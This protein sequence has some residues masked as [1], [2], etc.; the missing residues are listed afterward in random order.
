MPA[1]LPTHGLRLTALAAALLC[2]QAWPA[3]LDFTGAAPVF[4]A[5]G[6]FGQGHEAFEFA[7]RLDWEGFCNAHAQAQCD[8]RTF[9]G[10][11][12]NWAGGLRPGAADDVR[13]GTG[14]T[15]V[16]GSFN[17]LF[18]GLLPGYAQVNYLS[19]AG[20]LHI[21]PGSN[22]SA[23]QADIAHLDL[24]GV[25]SLQGGRL[26]GVNLSAG[27]LV[28]TG[29]LVVQTLTRTAGYI[30]GTGDTQILAIDA[31]SPSFSTLVTGGQRLGLSGDYGGPTDL[32]L[33]D[34]STFSTSGVLG[35][36]SI[37]SVITG[38]GAF[39]ATTQSTVVN[40]GTLLGG[41]QISG[42]RFNNDGVVRIDAGDFLALSNG[43]HSGS[44]SAGAGTTL[45]F[46]NLGSAGHVFL[47]NSTVQSD[48][49]V[50][51]Q[52]GPALVQGGYRVAVTEVGAGANVSFTGQPQ[53]F[54]RIQM[55]GGNLHMNT[56]AGVQIGVL[57]ITGASSVVTFG[58]G[59][60]SEVGDLRLDA[61]SA[62]LGAASGLQVTGT[63]TWGT[64][65]IFGGV[66]TPGQVLLVAGNR[67]LAGE[68]HNRGQA[69]WQG[70]SFSS[71]TGIWDNSASAALD[72]LGDF[73]VA[74]STGRF[75]N[76]GS[77]TK[78]AGAG[79]TTL[80][81]SFNNG[82]HVK[83]SSGALRLDGGGTQS[84]SFEATPGSWIELA[85]AQ[86][87]T[88]SVAPVGAVHITDGSLQVLA[89]ASYTNSP[90]SRIAVQAMQIDARGS[91]TNHGTVTGGAQI[92]NDGSLVNNG[93]WYAGKL[94]NQGSFSNSSGHTATLDSGISTGS[95]LNSGSLVVNTG[96]NVLG[97]FSNDGSIAN[98]GWLIVDTAL[99]NAGQ[100]SSDG[101]VVVNATASL[102][103]QGSFEQTAGLTT[104]NGL[105]EAQGGIN[106]RAGQLYG[107]G[108]LRG[109]VWV[110]SGA[111][112]HPGN[113]PGTL[114]VDGDATLAGAG[115]SI[116]VLD[117]RHSDLL[118]VSGVLTLDQTRI[119]LKFDPAYQPHD[120]DS[121]TWLRAARID[122]LGTTATFSGLPVD[123]QG[124]VTGSAT[125]RQ[126]F[127]LNDP[128]TTPSMQIA[129]SGRVQIPQGAVAANLEPVTVE[130]EELDNAGR[131]VNA[132]D[133]ALR[134]DRLINRQDATFSNRGF[135]EV[136]NQ[137]SNAGTLRV[138]PDGTLRVW[139]PL[140]NSGLLVSHGSLEL[141][142]GLNNTGSVNVG[143]G[144][145]MAL[146]GGDLVTDGGELIVS[147]GGRLQ[148]S[149]AILQRGAGN[150]LVV[151]GQLQ[152][153]LVRLFNGGELSGAGE[154]TGDVELF[155]A[156]I[157]I[158]STALSI[159]G[160][161]GL[162]GGQA[163]S[164]SLDGQAISALKVSGGVSAVG[165]NYVHFLLTGGY[166]PHLGDHY[167][168]L[169]AAGGVSG[170]ALVY[171]IYQVDYDANGTPSFRYYAPPVDMRVSFNGGEIAF[172]AAVPEPHPL[173]LMLLGLGAMAGRL[174]ARRK[175]EAP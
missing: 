115:L 105:L 42:A 130:L 22:L 78:S 62:G 35:S 6:D 89:G 157:D 47:P 147:S 72:I 104:V 141:H 97:R 53:G 88:G 27:T 121:F 56:Q 100:I 172:L 49:R 93:D 7:F 45:W 133:T 162:N 19:V 171:D 59:G 128:A 81:M 21:L 111:T 74:A 77:V 68:I 67:A 12:G 125:Q 151:D 146:D 11:A 75:D 87:I 86:R 167:T 174:G 123:W 145:S 144:G 43:T 142:G 28:N 90:A 23:T 140:D 127:V 3:I 113:S 44:F 38:G 50:L 39:N 139:A 65:S 117:H 4:L 173:L 164:V 124:L 119:E 63:L 20:D 161:L 108:T 5:E 14:Q 25:L 118:Q 99:H 15:A 30:S 168:W 48:G 156:A 101:V 80:G 102:Q 18:Q 1:F 152:A 16:L 34:A 24:N 106:I 94:L 126:V 41:F 2:G 153:P 33:E 66:T 55:D 82:G 132:P 138:R 83:V 163:F 52:S 114:S 76:A 136:F 143:P 109:P 69:Q 134:V 170:T 58:A 10:S 110:G 8:V 169:D 9:W 85:G 120:G 159:Q 40:T 155:N 95:F 61:P 32:V 166:L 37:K 29:N 137:A 135:M 103:G 98:H 73:V 96:L 149:G 112:V 154:I 46:G 84:G 13:I 175:G 165:L 107:T 57:E 129:Q 131:F 148:S 31:G 70:G 160:H 116:E 122:D 51:F 91:L 158:A 36:Q 150:R 92:N 26:G 17:S 71:W 60:V 79:Y 64:G 54:G